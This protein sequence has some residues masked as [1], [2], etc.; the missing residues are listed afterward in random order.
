MTLLRTL[1]LA[2][3][4]LAAI[5]CTNDQVVAPAQAPPAPQWAQ[6]EI[7]ALA[8]A[9][10][11][12]E[13]VFESPDEPEPIDTSIPSTRLEPERATKNRRLNREP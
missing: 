1:A 3:L 5:G 11:E 2:A 4:G 9:P 12:P 13:M 8:A 6:W 10:R 7:E